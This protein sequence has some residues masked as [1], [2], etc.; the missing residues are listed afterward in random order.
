MKPGRPSG[1]E[2]SAHAIGPLKDGA[3]TRKEKTAIVD[4]MLDR[5]HDL[6][7]LIVG[8]D[9]ILCRLLTTLEINAEDRE[10]GNYLRSFLVA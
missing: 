9:D 10:I 4:R 2:A 5:Y 8:D 7:G 1:D 6:G 3:M